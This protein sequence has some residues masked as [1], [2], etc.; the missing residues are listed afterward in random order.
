[1]PAHRAFSLDARRRPEIA[2]D[3][4]PRWTLWILRAQIGI[5]YFFA[6]VAKI[7]PDW[8]RGYPMRIEL[9]MARDYP[10]IGRYFDAE[11]MVY[12]FSYGGLLFDLL[13][14]PALCWKRTRPLAL[15]A[16][17]LFHVMN[18]LLYDID[19]FPWF[20]IAATLLFLP[21]ERFRP[22]G[23]AALPQ[24]NPPGGKERF[25]LGLFSVHFA[26]QV[27]V[28]FHH[29][30]YPS[31]SLWTRE[32]YYFSWRMK[33]RLGKSTNPHFLATDPASGR[34]WRVDAL[35][36][37]TRWQWE[38]VA[39]RP[40]LVL[41]L[42]HH[43]AADLRSQGYERIELRYRCRFAMNG[44]DPQWLIDPEVD[45]AAQPLS[46]GPKSWIVPLSEP[47]PTP[48]EL[49]ASPHWQ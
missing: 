6:G 48:A 22:G 13:V 21:P 11:W 14:V 5:P 19:I 31:E 42:A 17:V 18:A 23:G 43:I 38:R 20:M 32:G 15:A 25:L 40:E 1:V 39:T 30:L 34:T 45:L 3:S 41:P 33:L 47:L 28:P 49:R 24:P 2:G 44:R 37:L 29:W 35:Q 4:A 26:I 7:N 36:Y 12:L 46:L 10:L 8:L 9:R 27:L 16:A